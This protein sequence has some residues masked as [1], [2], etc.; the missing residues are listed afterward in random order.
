[1]QKRKILSPP[2]PLRVS[3]AKTLREQQLLMGSHCVARVS[4]VVASGVETPCVPVT[5]SPAPCP[6]AV[7]MISL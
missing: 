6:P 4:R 7:L 2:A 3:P 1:M 5:A